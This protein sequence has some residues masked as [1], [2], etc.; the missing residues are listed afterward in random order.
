MK[1]ELVQ[2]EKWVSNDRFNRVYAVYQVLPGPEAMELAYYFGYIA[3]GRLRSFLGGLGFLLP[4]F[5]LML[6]WS[7]VYVEFGID[8]EHVQ[9]SFNAVQCAVAAMI[10]RATYKLAEGALT[11]K[12]KDNNKNFNLILRNHFHG[13]RHF[14]VDFVS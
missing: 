4:G 8:N 12:D 9:R 13:K 3:K 10:F 1:Q 11:T 2:E 6:L 14:Y 5:C 7:F